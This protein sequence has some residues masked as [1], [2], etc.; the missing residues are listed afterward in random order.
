MLTWSLENAVDTAD[1]MNARGYGLENRT[2]FSLFKFTLRDFAVLMFIPGAAGVV[3]A[4]AAV[5]KLDFEYY[6]VI[7][8]GAVSVWTI[9]CY[10]LTGSLTLLPFITEIAESIKWKIS[11]SKI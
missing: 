10:V 8:S 2:H 1:S 9:V 6:P 3:L 4:A 7:K 5:G 11:V